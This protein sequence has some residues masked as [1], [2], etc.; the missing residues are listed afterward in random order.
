MFYLTKKKFVDLLSQVKFPARIFNDLGIRISYFLKL[1]Y[2]P[3]LPSSLDIEPVNYCNFRCPHC[4]VT[5]W[6]KEKKELDYKSFETLIKK[7][8]QL[9]WIKIQGMGEPLLNKDLIPMLRLGNERSIRMS[10]TSNGSI[11]NRN[12]AEKVANL[13]NTSI[14]FSIDGASAGVFEKIR[15][16]SRFESVCQNIK[17]LTEIIGQSDK[18]P[19]VKAW[20]VVTKSNLREVGDVVRLVERLGVRSITFQLFLNDWG[21]SEMSSYIDDIKLISNNL[22]SKEIVLALEQAKKIAKEIGVEIRIYYGDF[23]TKKRICSWPWK[24]SYICANGDVVPCSILADSET[25]KMGNVFENSLS[26]IWN[27]EKY[28]NFRDQHINHDLPSYCRHCYLDCEV[29]SKD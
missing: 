2:V 20:M 4:Q 9:I 22:S 6:Q 15:V 24:S 23:Y 7:L 27:S 28:R 13:D 12:I 10:F 3:F 1:S 19:Q 26:E 16:G 25:V 14:T 5:H 18:S 11:F 17:Q 8:P 21:K 29:N